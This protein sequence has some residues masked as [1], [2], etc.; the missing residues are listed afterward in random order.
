MN[1]EMLALMASEIKE[2]SSCRPKKVFF[3]ISESRLEMV[4]GF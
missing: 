1:G 3:V 4:L 2:S